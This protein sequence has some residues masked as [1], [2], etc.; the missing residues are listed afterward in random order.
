MKTKFRSL[1][2]VSCLFTGVSLSQ[3]SIVTWQAAVLN[4]TAPAVTL[5][6]TVLAGSPQVINVGN[7]S[8][9]RS[10]EFIYNA[11]V[12]GVSQALLGSQDT[13]SG[14]Q[15]LKVDQYL[16]TGMYGMTDFG[17]A[18]YTST[19]PY[20]LNQ[21]VDIVYVS[22]GVDTQMYLNGALAYTFVG[23]DL[24]IT[25][26]NGIG[27]ADDVAHTG[28]FDVLAGNVLGFASYD[29]ALS[30]AEVA[31]HY[32]SFVIPEPSMAGMASLAGLAA[33]SRRRRS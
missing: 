23:V 32:N 27:A 16:N 24:T 20:I 33:I 2:Y 6:T 29:S 31:T 28:F 1:F 30:P 22:N 10:F 26:L 13:A 12:G 25:G 11:G 21:D 18:D 5:F 8:G 17:V 7:L 19:V 3:A 4:G 14:R 15:G 9:D